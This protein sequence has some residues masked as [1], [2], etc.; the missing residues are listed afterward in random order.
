MVISSFSFVLAD[1]AKIES[2]GIEE[3]ELLNALGITDYEAE[4]LSKAVTRGEFY[5]VLCTMQGLPET[6]GTDAVFADVDPSNEYAGYIRTLAKLGVITSKD[7]K[8]YPDS[9][10]KEVTLLIGRTSE[11]PESTFF[12]PKDLWIF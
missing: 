6:K 8:I 7:G 11:K 1:E 4:D 3:M 2:C 12:S 5:K 9:P 10:I